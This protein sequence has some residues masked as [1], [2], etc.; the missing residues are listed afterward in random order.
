MCFLFRTFLL[1]LASSSKSDRHFFPLSSWTF[2]F[3]SLH[4]NWGYSKR[5]CNNTRDFHVLG[6]KN[7]SM[8]CL[9]RWTLPPLPTETKLLSMK[10]LYVLTSQPTV[11][12]SSLSWRQCDSFY[13]LVSL[14]FS[15]CSL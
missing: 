4:R 14:N 2:F 3:L 13:W 5:P 10:L 1:A 6:G 11:R 9:Q 12:G 7:K 15:F 8:F